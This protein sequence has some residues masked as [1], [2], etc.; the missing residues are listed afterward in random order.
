M[1]KT[2]VKSEADLIRELKQG[3]RS[4]FNEIYMMYFKRLYGYCLKL[5]K[6]KDLAE[7]IVQDVFLRLWNMR[8]EIKQEET[9]RS[10]LFII[11]KNYLIKS[12][13][14]M[15]HSLVFED[16]VSYQDKLKDEVSADSHIEYNEFL[17][18]LRHEIQKLP[19]TQQKVIELTKLKQY[20]VKEVAQQLSLSEQTVRNQLSIGLK[21]LKDLLGNVPI[22]LLFI[23]NY[24]SE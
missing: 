18:R 21:T 24:L 7:D 15:I 16:Y 3:S 8:A 10:L 5:S 4:A 11:S 14:N 22:L 9:V 19:Q 2:K 6:D 1:S 17:T 13:Y 23:F 12:S 20:S